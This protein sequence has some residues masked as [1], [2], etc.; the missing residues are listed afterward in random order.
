[1][2]LNQEQKKAVCHNEGPM[3]VLAGPGSGKTAV[4]TARTVCLIEKYHIAPSSILVVTFTRA[5]AGEM[6]ERFLSLTKGKHSQVQFGTFHG[7]FYGILKQAYHLNSGN[8]MGEAEKRKLLTELVQNSRM[9]IDDEK[10]TLEVLEQEISTVKTE[11]IALDHFYSSGCPEEIFRE[12]FRS[13]QKEMRRRRMLDFDDLMVCCY[14][15]FIK[16]PDILKRWQ[17]RF[18]YVLVDEFQDVNMLQYKIIRMLASPED[19]LFVVGDDDQSI[20]R[21]R[22][23]RPEI[24]LSFLNDYPRGARITLRK[25]YRCTKAIVNCSQRLIRENEKR[26]E[27]KLETDNEQGEA[28]EIH[29]FADEEAQGRHL[30]ETILEKEKDG[31]P[32]EKMAVLFRTNT[33]SRQTVSRLMEYNIPFVIKDSLPNLYEHWIARQILSYLR[34]SRGGRMRSDFLT[35]MNKPN[36]YIS[37]EALY[38]KE[39]SFES[40]YQYYEEKEWMCDRIGKLEEDLKRMGGMA[41]F[42]AI[43]YLCCGMGYR[44]Y[45]VEYAGKRKLKKEDLLEILDEIQESSRKYRTFEEW[46]AYIQEYTLLL[47]KQK[48]SADARGVTIST[49]HGSKGLEYDHVFIL[50]VNEGTIPYHKAALE[51]D[52]EEE[53]RLLYVGMTR[54]RKTLHLFYPE[55]RYR[56]KQS[57]SRFLE[58]ILGEEIDD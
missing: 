5:A 33:E 12:I 54:A 51:E 26:Y 31:C 35:V 20:Y 52:L 30:A 25:N 24:M 29:P 15:L 9:E 34:L 50:N 11:Q 47:Q 14:D 44:D 40:L 4:I 37:R 56:K 49:L 28:V 36:R 43:N 21:F 8:I 16:R 18:R 32:L 42:A 17:E 13:Y 46:C 45:I 22:G 3:L 23:A 10:D 6:K 1:M 38:E 2:N 19:N 55:K 53:R 39:V 27:K 7:I 41:P 57:P 58:E 48:N